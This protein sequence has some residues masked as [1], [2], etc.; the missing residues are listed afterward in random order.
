MMLRDAR[1]KNALVAQKGAL[2]ARE[3]L[4][5]ILVNAEVFSS[6]RIPERRHRGTDK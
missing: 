6:L 3:F 4:P 2:D 1:G 5:S